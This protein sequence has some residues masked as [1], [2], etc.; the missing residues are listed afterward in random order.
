[1]KKSNFEILFQ[2]V[3][4]KNPIFFLILGMCPTLAVTTS[5]DNGIGMGLATSFVILSSCLLISSIRK[6]VPND[7]RIPASIVIIASFVT[8]ASM[9]M[10]A[11]AP[12]LFLRLGIYVPLIV[13]NCIVLGRALAF[14]YKNSIIPSFFDAL[15]SGLGF[16]V[17]LV[18][19]A[20]LREIIGTGSLAFLG[21][22]LFTIPNLS[23]GIMIL[24]PG[25]LLIMGL[26]LGLF[27]YAKKW[28]TS[29]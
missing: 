20:S 18:L 13:V 12:Q 17:A 24:P 27:N 1:M 6:I 7:I 15:G 16:T 21:N 4:S 22:T 28:K 11:Y 3:F 5:L 2:G 25:A 10:E 23:V 8:I 14:S 19:I 9:I 29:S 26:L